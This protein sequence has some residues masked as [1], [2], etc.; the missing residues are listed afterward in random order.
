MTRKL[1]M[2]A[3]GCCLVAG[4]AWAG[5]D[6]DYATPNDDTAGSTYNRL[7]HNTSQAHDLMDLAGP[8]VDEDWMGVVSEPYQSYEVI[9]DG[10][11]GTVAIPTRYAADGTTNLGQGAGID[12]LGGAYSLRWANTTSSQASDLVKI[13]PLTT[14]N[15]T[16][17]RYD[18][19]MWETTIRM[20]RFNCSGTQ[21][22]VVMCQNPTRSSISATQYYWN[23]AGT[24]V[25]ANPITVGGRAT[26]VVS[27]CAIG[28]VNTNSGSITV[29][30]NGPYGSL[31][32]KAV[33]VEPATGFTFDTVG[34]YRP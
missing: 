9:A 7:I 20:A 29:A 8:A 16:Y 25:Y 27:S 1:L 5:D 28:A 6:W 22:T 15:N 26:S 11:A 21:V 12:G 4:T 33:A 14:G 3:L 23:A 10:W 18:L 2:L 32:C 19:R 30:H 34:A 13:A 24:L 31:N 17:D